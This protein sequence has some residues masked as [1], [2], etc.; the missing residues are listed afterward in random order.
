[1][2]ERL[3]SRIAPASFVNAKT[4]TYTDTDGDLVSVKL[5]QPLF[6][7]TNAETVFQFDSAFAET[8]PQQLQLV[9]LATLATNGLTL[10]VISKIAGNGD[11]LAAVGEVNSAGFDLAKVV[12][13]GDLG[14]LSAG[15][16][17]TSTPA[18]KSFAA[19]SMGRYGTSTQAIGGGLDS[20]LIGSVGKIA[21]RHDVV[22]AHIA[23]TGGADGKLGA[24]VIGGSLIGT[25]DDAA[26]GIVSTTGDIGSIKIGKDLVGAESE[27]QSGAVLAGGTVNRVLIRGSI[28]ASNGNIASDA[29]LSATSF[30][31][32]TIAGDLRGGAAFQSGSI[33]A[34]EGGIV[35]LTVGGS[36]VGADGNQ[37][38]Q[39]LATQNSLRI[40]VGGDVRGGD[41]VG[42]GRIQ[43]GGDL[44][45]VIVRGSLVGGNGVSDGGVAVLALLPTDGSGQILGGG[46]I[47][48][49]TISHDVRGG[50][51]DNSGKIAA[52]G[53]L[54]KL[55][56]GGSVVGGTGDQTALVSEGAGGFAIASQISSQSDMG[57]VKIGHD[58]RGDQ[59][60]GTGHIYSEGKM[61]AV[62]VGGSLV[63]G[64]G[65]QT[66][67]IS[68]DGA[69]GA[70][71]I[72]GGIFGAVGSQSGSIASQDA[73]AK[74]S[75]RQ[76]LA[77]GSG[78]GSGRIAAGTTLGAIKIGG[79]VIGTDANRAVISASGV[80]APADDA[81]ALAMNKIKIAG[82]VEFGQI[83]AGYQELVSA[84]NPDAQ[85]GSII[86]AGDWVASDLVAGVLPNSFNK[87]GTADDTLA[88]GGNGVLSKIARV[89]I[90]GQVL[91]TP[92]SDDETDHYGIVAELVG[93]VKVAKDAIPLQSDAH[94]DARDL[95]ITNDFTIREV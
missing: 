15:D 55:T 21:I 82:R 92:S 32:I 42:S 8:G 74:I 69:V 58:V 68:A 94:N 19:L 3:E 46:N 65:A 93:S 80:S 91:G 30:G 72:G 11:G 36:V 1:M 44:A 5:S 83:L 22:G 20:S 88:A 31:A 29:L 39:I 4:V 66:G 76:D 38:G 17:A 59:G 13:D 14:R 26:P 95:G 67:R 49:I 23:I 16:A 61:A 41:G 9:N 73:I 33:N 60:I 90:K 57:R 28:L 77:G 71:K 64:S 10:K 45:S 53:T 63:G 24:V 43:I 79:N 75:V 18:V 40:N 2:I 78:N 86:V 12:I 54:A 87:F 62:S 25:D 34:T 37:S 84:V 27:T 47:G 51:A 6:T 56:I 81:A 70:V 35:S 89:V 7:Q 85:I 48:R 50:A 52:G